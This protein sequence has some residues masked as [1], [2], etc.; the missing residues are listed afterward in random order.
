LRELAEARGV[1]VP[2]RARKSDLIAILG[3]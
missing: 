2:K 1:E 3:A